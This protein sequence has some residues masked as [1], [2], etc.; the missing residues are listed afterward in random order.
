[1]LALIIGHTHISVPGLRDLD[2]AEHWYRHSLDLRDEAD[3]Y[4][5][6]RCL[7]SFG[8]LA[9]ERFNDA[10]A[11]RQPGPVLL[12]HLNA[13]LRSYL[14]ALDLTPAGD[15]ETRTGIENQ[16]GIVCGRAGKPVRRWRITRDPFTMRVPPTRLLQP[17]D[18]SP[19]SG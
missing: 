6:A 5:R 9:M 17:S 18:S 15:H 8:I 19:G 7:T 16:P 14:Q 1:M 12:E 10:H 13:A 11:E 2:Q 4:D 3:Q